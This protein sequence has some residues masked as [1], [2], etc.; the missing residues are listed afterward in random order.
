MSSSWSKDDE[1]YEFSYESEEI[2]M[3]MDA[4]DEAQRQAQTSAPGRKDVN[5]GGGGAAEDDDDDDNDDDDDYG[6]ESFD[7]EALEIPSLNEIAKKEIKA[8]GKC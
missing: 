2:S 1:T 7:A 4:E 3:S 5:G 6:D 8:S